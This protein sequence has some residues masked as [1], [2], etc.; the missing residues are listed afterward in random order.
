MIILPK[1]IGAFFKTIYYNLISDVEKKEI[2]SCRLSGIINSLAG[3]K[4]WYRP[5]LD[6]F[7]IFKKINK[8]MSKKKIIVTGGAGFVGTNLIKL[9]IK[10]TNYKII[11]LDNYSSGA[12]KNHIKNSRVKYIKADTTD[13]SKIIKKPK[14]LK[15][16]F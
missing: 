13:I 11:S 10:K 7:S 12:K 5:S 6:W 8:S 14:H 15:G 9:L 16:W 4:S 2:Y 1:L 3:K